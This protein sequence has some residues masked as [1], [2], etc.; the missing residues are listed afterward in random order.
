MDMRSNN[1]NTSSLS[2]VVVLFEA[3]AVAIKAAPTTTHPTIL[4]NQM[5]ATIHNTLKARHRTKVLPLATTVLMVSRT[6]RHT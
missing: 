5:A 6:L 2:E 4:I 3:D 1:R